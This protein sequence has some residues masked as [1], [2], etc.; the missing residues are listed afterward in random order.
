MKPSKIPLIFLLALT[1]CDKNPPIAEQE[2]AAMKV[3]TG[4]KTQDDCGGRPCEAQAFFVERNLPQG[5][6]AAPG[7]LKLSGPERASL[8]TALAATKTT[9]SSAHIHADAANQQLVFSADQ[10]SDPA[11]ASHVSGNEPEISLTSGGPAQ[12][13]VATGPALQLLKKRAV[14]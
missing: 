10:P 9:G 1:A 7:K 6:V 5:A 2:P 11:A 13:V 14:R 3:N 8:T 4:S 12:K